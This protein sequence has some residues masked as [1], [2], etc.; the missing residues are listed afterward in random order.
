M[1][2]I[3]GWPTGLERE[4]FPTIVHALRFAAAQNPETIAV[5]CL[6]ETMTYQE[7]ESAAASF[8]RHL[9]DQGIAVAHTAIFRGTNQQQLDADTSVHQRE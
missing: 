6:G 1:A 3:P 5:V 4:D 7:L 8:A 9:I 2:Q